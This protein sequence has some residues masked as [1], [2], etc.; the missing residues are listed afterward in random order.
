MLVESGDFNFSLDGLNRKRAK[1]L[2]SSDRYDAEVLRDIATIMRR[3]ADP[4]NEVG[5]AKLR[6]ADDLELI[7]GRL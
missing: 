3:K 7:A 2:V 6:M 1:P 4:F 5:R